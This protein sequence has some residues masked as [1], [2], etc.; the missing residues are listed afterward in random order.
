MALSFLDQVPQPGDGAWLL[1]YNNKQRRGRG[2][3]QKPVASFLHQEDEG[4]Y[5]NEV[6]EPMQV[7]RH[8]P[9]FLDP[10]R[11]E[12]PT[13]PSTPANHVQPRTVNNVLLLSPPVPQRQFMTSPDGSPRAEDNYTHGGRP[14]V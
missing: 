13:P 3:F 9:T 4:M 2:R 10:T 5:Q 11:K 12:L 7:Q 14:C 6:H 1:Q 8:L